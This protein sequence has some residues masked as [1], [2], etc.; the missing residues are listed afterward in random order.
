MSAPIDIDAL[1]D[2]REGRVTSSIYTDP[3]IYELELERIF[4]RCWLFLA[5]VSQIPKAGDFF[6]T[7]MGEDPV[8]VVRQKDGSIKAFLNQCR[9]RSMRVSFADCGNTRAFTCPYHGW[10]YGV[11]GALIDVPLEPRAYPHGLC[12]EK[13]GLQEVTRVTVYKGLVFGNWDASAP[14]LEAYMGDIAWYLDGV[15]DRR[16]GGTEIIGGVHKWVID[17]NWKFPAEQFASDQYHALFSHASAVQVLGAKEG[18]GDKA[19]GAGQTARPV[20]ETAK[21]ALQ[22][23]QAGHGSGFFFT[24]QPD[25]NVWVDGEVS[26]YFRDTYAE[27]EARLGKVRALRLAGHNNLFPTMSWLNGTATLRVWHPRGPNQVEV[28]AFCIAD[29]DA[30]DDVKAAFERSATRAFGPAGFLEQDD[31]E[32]WV[33]IQKVLRG[34]RARNT[35]L[36]V[37]MG[38]GNERVRDDGIPGVTNYIFSETAARGMYRRWADLLT[39]DSWDEVLDRTKQYEAEVLK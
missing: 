16:E 29:K 28:W 35:K 38:L 25:A 9:H 12:K 7:Y 37:E 27:A 10:S 1:V 14:D 23:G 36:I 33:E 21:D 39:S 32:N 5:H 18:E 2:A 17:C 6:N 30:S 11:D 8:V 3:A 19:L 34:K 24:E 22:Y 4:G 31:S 13:L 15:L 20:W 26:Q